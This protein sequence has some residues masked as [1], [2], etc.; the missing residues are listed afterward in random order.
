MIHLPEPAAA[1]AEARQQALE[2][3]ARVVDAN[4]AAC[5]G[6]SSLIAHILRSNAAAIRALMDKATP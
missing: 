4:A 5:D 1:L 3:A 6:H 2:D